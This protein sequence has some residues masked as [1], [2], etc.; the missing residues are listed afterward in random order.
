MGLTPPPDWLLAVRQT[1]AYSVAL[2]PGLLAECTH[3]NTS[4]TLS[5][6][7]LHTTT[8]TASHTHSNPTALTSSAPLTTT[9]TDAEHTHNTPTALS[10]APLDASAEQHSAS[11][12]S[13]PAESLPH[14]S[15]ATHTPEQSAHTRTAA[16][17]AAADSLHS[18]D[19]SSSQQ[20]APPASTTPPN[21]HVST[22]QTPTLSQ[23]STSRPF[24]TTSQLVSTTQLF[25]D[26][27]GSKEDQ[28][29]LSR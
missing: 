6:S 10:P 18:S 11:L 20:Q 21:Q 4:T 14:D 8:A 3:S 27:L 15:P 2:P 23:A 22:T 24:S 25:R 12:T 5:S 1:V 29:P 19:V 26:L 28:P 9:A 7:K 13:S 16:A 17:S